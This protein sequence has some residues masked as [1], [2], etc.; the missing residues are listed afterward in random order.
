MRTNYRNKV[1]D[2]LVDNHG[3]IDQQTASQLLSYIMYHNP[4]AFVRAYEYIHSDTLDKIV[5]SCVERNRPYKVPAIKEVR[6]KTRVD[7]RRAK[8]LVDAAW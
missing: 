1:C 3:Q 2:I 8:E 4:C 7:L 5:R 6:E